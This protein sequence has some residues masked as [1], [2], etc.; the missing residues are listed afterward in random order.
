M[1]QIIAMGGGGFSMEPENPLL[2]QYILRQSDKNIPKICFIPTASGDAESYIERFYQAFE[3]HAA[4]PTHLALSNPPTT[5][6]EDFVLQQ[7]I[8]YVGG[9]NTENMLERW[10][11]TGLD[12]IIRKAWEQGVILSGLSAGSICWYEQGVSDSTPGELTS[13]P[14]LGLLQGSSCPHYDGEEDRR[15]NYH[16][17]MREGLITGGIAMDD[18]VGVHYVEQEIKQVISSRPLGRAYLV[19][20]EDNEIVESEI[21]PIYLGS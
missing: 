4:Q 1:R 12:Q 14:C 3:Q 19:A 18:G 20:R 10:K 9:G 15:P 7:D 21:V 6:L 8:L 17:L 5:D 13:L 11:E 16:R 2:D